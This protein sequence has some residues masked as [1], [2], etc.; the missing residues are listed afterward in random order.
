VE[1]FSGVQ[2][3]LQEQIGPLRA[4]L[5]PRRVFL[6]LEDKAITAMALEGR[7][8][9]WLERVVLPAGLCENGEPVRTDSLG[10]L[11]GDLLVERGY[12]GARVDAVLPPA[13][14]QLRLVQW[15][16]GR[17]PDDPE[18][19][20]ALN[21]E[22]L[23]LKTAL[24][25]LDLHLVDLEREVPTSLLVTVPSST[26]D[27]WIEVFGLAGVSLDRMEAAKPCVCRGLQPLLQEQRPGTVCV[28]LQLEPERSGLLV[29]ENDLPVYQRRLPGTGKPDALLD[30][31]K[32]SLEF[33]RQKRPDCLDLPLLLQHG[34]GL[35]DADR[36]AELAMAVGCPWQVIDPLLHG[37]L[38][39]VSP[40]LGIHPEGH[41]LA[42]LWG[43]AAA[44][45][46]P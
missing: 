36:A 23:A 11:L 17:W 37:W 30:E 34:S 18:R 27:R 3:R 9:V 4:W 22:Q 16:D 1:L 8:I 42:A 28:V 40:D 13:A 31:L 5:F 14:S 41:T 46:M 20:L 10:D 21:E 44:E 24:Q 25:Y 7:R 15:P 35:L 33:C 39:D 32:L 45:V 12:A 19:M 38:V 26:L 2:E 29:L 43:L 6:Q